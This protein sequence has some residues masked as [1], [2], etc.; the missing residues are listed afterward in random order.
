MAEEV[1]NPFLGNSI[2]WVDVNKIR[3][4]PFQPRREFD[5]AR[6]K[7]M[8][9]S[10]RA[11]G[12]LQPL[13]VTRKEIFNED[14]LSTEYELI[15]GERRLRASKIA[16]VTQVP[17]II[18]ADAESD[19]IKLELAIIENLQREDI[20]ALDRAMA[21]DKLC[22]EFGL[23]HIEIAKKIGKSREYVSNTIRLLMLPDEM[24]QALRDGKI[25]EG[26]TRP[27]LMLGD[28]PE[29][30][31]TLFKEI[32]VKR[33]SVREAERISRKI[34]YDKARKKEYVNNPELLDLEERLTEKLGTRVQI[35]AKDFGGRVTID[36]FSTNDLRNFLD[37]VN[38][39]LEKHFGGVLKF[40]HPDHFLGAD[41][42]EDKLAES[43]EEAV[44]ED[45]AT[46]ETPDSDDQDLYSVNSF[47]I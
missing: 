19:K 8:A 38:T 9:D 44:E 18:K 7:D 12:I 21:F 41:K 17:V 37:L 33:L 11:Y 30:Q 25:N 24:K 43:L 10:I 32:I 3:P 6:L 36:Y 47:S 26:H 34:A 14:G 28:R 31:M 46:I 27:L 42:Q 15:A 13:T 20:S 2:F 5:E 16:G 23:K 22:R 4:N 45:P 35:E 39:S 1:Q 29:E 40:D